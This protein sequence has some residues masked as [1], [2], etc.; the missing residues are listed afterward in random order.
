MCHIGFIFC[1][2]IPRL[3]ADAVLWETTAGGRAHVCEQTDETESVLCGACAS[4]L[5]DLQPCTES[6]RVVELVT[7]D[8]QWERERR[9][10]N[11]DG[12]RGARERGPCAVLGLI[13]LGR[14]SRHPH[15]HQCTSAEK[16][17]NGQTV[18]ANSMQTWLDNN[19]LQNRIW[20]RWNQQSLNI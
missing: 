18:P 17:G 20:T 16:L 10:A 7:D 19:Y 3:F 8:N 5:A 6:R 2:W 4:T 1:R 15:T 12:P 11:S 14:R 13:P 9:T